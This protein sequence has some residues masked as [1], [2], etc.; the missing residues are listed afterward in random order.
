MHFDAAK[1]ACIKA[2][3]LGGDYISAAKDND[4]TGTLTHATHQ[5]FN[6]DRYTNQKHCAT[7]SSPQ[8]EPS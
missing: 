6:L 4:A 1:A 2:D 3:D 5:E 7:N 8:G